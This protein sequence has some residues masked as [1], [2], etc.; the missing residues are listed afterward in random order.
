MIVDFNYYENT[1]KGDK[2]P[3]EDFER[4]EVQAS[5]KVMMYIMNRDYAN[6]HGKDYTEQVKLATCSVADILY[7]IEQTQNVINS[8]IKGGQN[9]II[10]SEKVADYSRSYGTATFKELQEKVSK[11]NVN[12]EI[13]DEVNGYLLYTGLMNRGVRVV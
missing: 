3:Q 6:W 9:S 1:Y 10:T 7:D 13:Q 11:T 8:V 12:K 5:N 2:I 4:I